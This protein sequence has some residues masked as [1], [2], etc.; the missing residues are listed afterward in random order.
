MRYFVSGHRDLTKEE[1]DQHYIPFIDFIISED[2]Y[3]SFVVGDWVGCDSMFVQYM[4]AFHSDIPI[5]IF[6]VDI[7]RIKEGEFNRYS[8]RK[9]DNYDKCDATMTACSHFD[10]TWI[11]PGKEDSHTAKNVKRRYNLC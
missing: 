7:P 9:C 11:R 1:F 2:S 10:I 6:Y 3:A 4:E 5:V 8:F